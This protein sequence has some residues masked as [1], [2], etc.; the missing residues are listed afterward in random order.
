M[1]A[2][3]WSGRCQHAQNQKVP[4]L[5]QSFARGPLARGRNSDHVLEFQFCTGKGVF[6]PVKAC[7][8]LSAGAAMTHRNFLRTLSPEPRIRIDEA[9]FPPAEPFASSL[10]HFLAF[11]LQPLSS[12]SQSTAVHEALRASAQQFQLPF[13]G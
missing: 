6:G 13:P 3:Y 11:G 5:L 7:S 12:P 10:V 4:S 8:R 2:I 1:I 9:A